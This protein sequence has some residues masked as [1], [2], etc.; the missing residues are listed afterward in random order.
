MADWTRYGKTNYRPINMKAPM[1]SGC[2]KTKQSARYHLSRACRSSVLSKAS[3]HAP[4]TCTMHVQTS[5]PP[6]Q[7]LW[8]IRIHHSQ[9]ALCNGELHCVEFDV[10]EGCR[11]QRARLKTCAMVPMSTLTDLRGRIASIG[12][13]SCCRPTHLLNTWLQ[14][15]I[16][17]ATVQIPVTAAKNAT[18]SLRSP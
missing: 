8:S 2:G 9:T 15:A 1:L 10:D 7:K 12:T 6:S 5:H 4:C 11:D 13:W 17:C 16:S 18:S 3:H 14:L